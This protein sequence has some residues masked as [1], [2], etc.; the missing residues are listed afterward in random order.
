MP[1][2][3][4]E[5]GERFVIPSYRDVLTVKQKSQLKKDILLLSQ[6]YGE[7]IT[8]QRKGAN[9]YEVAFSPDTGYLL[10]ESIWHHFKRPMD[11]I[12]CEAIPNTTEAIL[13][14]VKD[15]SVYLDGSFPVDSIPEELVIF[16]TQQN[17]F[18]IYIYG[19]VPISQVPEAGK[20]SFE[21]AAVKSFTVLDKPVFPTLPLLKIYQLQPVDLVLKANAI[22]VLPT[23]QIVMALL[24]VGGLWALYAY[25]TATPVITVQEQEALNP[26]QAYLNILSSPAP[27]KELNKLVTTLQMFYTLPGWNVSGAKY[28]RNTLVTMVKSTGGKVEELFAWAKINNMN[29]DIKQDG[30]YL[31]KGL[32]FANRP[33]PINIY[34]VKDVMANFIDNLALVYPGNR[35]K[36]GDMKNRGQFKD[37]TFTILLSGVSTNVIGLIGSQLTNL[38]FVLQSVS[39]DADKKNNFSGSITLEVLGS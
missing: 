36:I 12:Y 8:M 25:L 34:P 32:I 24:V 15:G 23:K 3:T 11:M 28:T 22:G 10:G 1:Y 2:I 26:Y 5:D 30:I 7:Y 33:A 27:D 14:I 4:R 18:E 16:L 37:L 29:T 31:T 35:L 9:A 21:Q 39:I 13:V 19:E 38:P 6:S 20:F 17:N